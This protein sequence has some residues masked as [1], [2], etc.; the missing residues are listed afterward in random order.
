[1]CTVALKVPRGS[2]VILNSMSSAVVFI[3]SANVPLSTQEGSFG[4]NGNP[5]AFLLGKDLHRTPL[6]FSR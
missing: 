3:S 5:T 6:V 2:R 4:R 1:M